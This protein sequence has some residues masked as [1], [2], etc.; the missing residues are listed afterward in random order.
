MYDSANTPREGPMRAAAYTLDSF[1][2]QTGWV[3]SILKR[4]LAWGD[5][6]LDGV[7]A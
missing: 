1:V 3:D 5:M 4:D 2:E 7:F 6:D